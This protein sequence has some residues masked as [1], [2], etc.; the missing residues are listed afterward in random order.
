MKS[1][2]LLDYL[3]HGDIVK[4]AQAED[5]VACCWLVTDEKIRKEGRAKVLEMFNAKLLPAGIVRSPLTKE[6]FDVQVSALMP[7]VKDIH[8]AWVEAEK[9]CLKAREA[10]NPRAF[11]VA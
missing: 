2:T 4:A 1:L 10:G 8:S 3:A 5:K 9:E 11:F 6:T 7:M